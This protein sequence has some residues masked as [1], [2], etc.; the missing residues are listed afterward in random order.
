MSLSECIHPLA[1]DIDLLHGALLSGMLE[2]FSA[3]LPQSIKVNY[4]DPI[5][6]AGVGTLRIAD[7]EGENMSAVYFPV[8]TDDPTWKIEKGVEKTLDAAGRVFI[9]DL[10]G[11][12]FP[13]NIDNEQILSS[14]M[15]FDIV[16]SGIV[17]FC[18]V[19]GDYLPVLAEVDTENYDMFNEWARTYSSLQ[20]LVDLA[21]SY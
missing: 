18:G 7:W 4:E 9:R 13:I 21:S 6:G 16:G 11:R 15:R 14:F 17:F 12:G 19:E 5:G 2:D 10:L 20:P 1:Q 3:H 8:I